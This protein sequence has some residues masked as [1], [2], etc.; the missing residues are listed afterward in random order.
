MR[1]AVAAFIVFAGCQVGPPVVALDLESSE[2]LVADGTTNHTVTVCSTGPSPADVA[3]TLAASSGRFPLAETSDEDTATFHLFPT[4]DA[5][6]SDGGVESRC[7]EEPWEPSRAPGPVRFTVSAADMIVAER[8]F[9]TQAT[10]VRRLRIRGEPNHLPDEGPG[11]IAL[12]L[13]IEVASGGLPSLGTEV[14][15]SVLSDPPGAAAVADGPIVVGTRDGLVLAVAEGTERVRVTAS[16]D[17]VLETGTA[18]V[19]QE[20]RAF[21]PLSRQTGDGC[22][23]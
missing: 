14:E 12:S 1:L 21:R 4:T 17:S 2:S 3:V 6:V 5:G 9:R 11:R 16:A 18:T 7:H 23:P 22:A 13:D 8:T 15:V 19:V 10:K 20:C